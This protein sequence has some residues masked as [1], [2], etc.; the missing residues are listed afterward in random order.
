MG[1]SG[2]TNQKVMLWMMT[3]MMTIND[4]I[5]SN[6]LSLWRGK[7]KSRKP[8]E[9]VEDLD[10]LE[11]KRIGGELLGGLKWSKSS[12]LLHETD[13]SMPK[14]YIH[15]Y[16]YTISGLVLLN[17]SRPRLNRK[18]MSSQFRNEKLDEN[19]LYIVLVMDHRTAK[20]SGSAAIVF[21]WQ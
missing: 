17:V 10:K 5:F 1:L 3:V 9:Q 20:K 12:N 16:S 8:E 7:V 19:R 2:M 14:L 18:T 15:T 11:L 6:Y 21:T 13:L 4:D